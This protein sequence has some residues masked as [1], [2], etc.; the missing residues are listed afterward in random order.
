M[1]DNRRSELEGVEFVITI[2]ASDEADEINSVNLPGDMDSCRYLG[3][4]STIS[5]IATTAGKS[6]DSV[7]QP[8]G[9]LKILLLDNKSF[10]REAV[11][12]R[13]LSQ[14]DLKQL[15][16]FYETDNVEKAVSIVKDNP[17]MRHALVDFN[18]GS[19][20]NGFDFIKNQ[21]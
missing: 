15:I 16:I 11:K 10:Y 3:G 4:L 21:E 2:L 14:D 20:S 17:D 12:H 19:C 5:N 6:E 7:E 18:L 8:Y 9:L 1:N 13:V